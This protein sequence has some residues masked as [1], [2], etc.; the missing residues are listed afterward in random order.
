MCERDERSGERPKKE[1][2]YPAK[3]EVPGLRILLPVQGTCAEGI[4]PRMTD[5]FLARPGLSR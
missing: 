3:Q 1:E 2:K 4:R 5:A